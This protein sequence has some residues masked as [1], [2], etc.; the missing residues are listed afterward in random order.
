MRPAGLRPL[1]S[2]KRHAHDRSALRA[3][4]VMPQLQQLSDGDRREA[5]AGF[6]MRFAQ[7]LGIDGDSD[8]GASSSADEEEAVHL[9]QGPPG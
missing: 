4:A 7:M 1:S 2:A 3:A 5:A 6:A 9:G 8:A